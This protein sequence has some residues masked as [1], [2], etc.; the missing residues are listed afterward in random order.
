MSWYFL[1]SHFNT[2]TTTFGIFPKLNIHNSK[3]VHLYWYHTTSLYKYAIH[4]VE[5]YQRLLSSFVRQTQ[6]L[7]AY[8]LPSPN[9]NS[10]FPSTSQIQ[11]ISYGICSYGKNV[12]A[13]LT[14]TINWLFLR[15]CIDR[16]HGCTLNWPSVAQIRSSCPEYTTTVSPDSK[17]VSTNMDV[18][19]KRAIKCI[20]THSVLHFMQSNRYKRALWCLLVYGGGGC[21]SQ[22]A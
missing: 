5:F 12:N 7:I 14:V 10:T 8:S 19:S 4:S 20:G 15:V 17:R 9:S 18:G 22:G 16:L 1:P 13:A 11:T 6:T 3:S 2:V 21:I